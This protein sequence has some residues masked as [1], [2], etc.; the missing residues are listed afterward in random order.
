MED[1]VG[2]KM[3]GTVFRFKRFRFQT[4][5]NQEREENHGKSCRLTVNALVMFIKKKS[6][7]DVFINDFADV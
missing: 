5:R 1:R 2:T 4:G 7:C 6:G 3:F